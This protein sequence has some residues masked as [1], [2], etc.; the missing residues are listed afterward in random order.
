MTLVPIVSVVVIPIISVVVVPVVSVVVPVVTPVI[1]A[2]PGLPADDDLPPRAG[3][4]E[5]ATAIVCRS[6]SGPSERN[7][8]QHRKRGEGYLNPLHTS[9]VRAWAT[10]VTD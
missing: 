3:A 10:D 9:I 2:P 1:P 4:A 5:L 7:P 6:R 8:R